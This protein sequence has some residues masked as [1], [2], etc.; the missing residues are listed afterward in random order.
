MLQC[1]RD[2]ALTDPAHSEAILAHTCRYSAVL[3]LL[4]V[5]M[6]RLPVCHVP[7]AM[8]AT[9]LACPHA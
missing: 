2:A 7:T 3:R 9:L 8:P 5:S 1:Y 4:A 6:G